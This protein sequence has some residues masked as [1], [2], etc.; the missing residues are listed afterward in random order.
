MTGMGT[1]AATLPPSATFPPPFLPPPPPNGEDGPALPNDV[2]SEV[3]RVRRNN[4]VMMGTFVFIICFLFVYYA[5]GGSGTLP[6]VVAVVVA[7]VVSP[8]LS[9]VFGSRDALRW[10]KWAPQRIRILSDRVVGEFDPVPGLRTFSAFQI[11]KFQAGMR[12]FGKGTLFGVTRVL[13]FP[14]PRGFELTP[15]P[16]STRDAPRPAYTFVM[17]AANVRAVMEAWIAWQRSPT[18]HAP[19]PM[20]LQEPMHFPPQ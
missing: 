4:V 18:S 9:Y 6:L 20:P 12:Y 15:R 2:S 3:A 10:R 13:C 16:G 14:L 7:A 19:P 17:T 8:L 11:L 1:V 5:L